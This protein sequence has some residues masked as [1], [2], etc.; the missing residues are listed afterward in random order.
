MKFFNTRLFLPTLIIVILCLLPACA[1]R[2][3]AAPAPTSKVLFEFK[4]ATDGPK[5]GYSLKAI[6]GRKD[7]VYVSD[8]QADATVFFTKDVESVGAGL[9][10]GDDD[11]FAVY[12]TFTK[13]GSEKIS[14]VTRSKIGQKL[15]LVMKG[16]VIYAATVREELS[17]G[18]MITGLGEKEAGELAPDMFRSRAA[19]TK[20]KGHYDP[21]RDPENWPANVLQAVWLPPQAQNTEYK[22]SGAY[23]VTYTADI[24]NRADELIGS[25]ARSMTGKKWERLLY[26]PRE[27]HN[28]SSAVNDPNDD[29]AWTHTWIECWRNEAGDVIYYRFTPSTDK[30]KPSC[31]IAAVIDYVPARIFVAGSKLMAEV[32]R[33]PG[34]KTEVATWPPYVLDSVWLPQMAERTKYDLFNGSYQ[35]FYQAGVCY[36]AKG[37]IDGM[38]ESMTAKGWRRLPYDPMNPGLKSAFVLDADK[39]EQLRGMSWPGSAWQDHWLDKAGNVVFYDYRYD[40]TY[41]SFLQFER[42][43]RKACSLQG[44]VIYFPAAVWDAGLNF[45]EEIKKERHYKSAPQGSLGFSP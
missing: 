14:Q 38:V 40:V 1:H 5:A 37:I 13:T 17:H 26:D 39:P 44:S 4:P 33:V 20:E 41:S 12:I 7:N 45:F 19:E 18:L 10:P 9:S 30:E 29:K 23:E 21:D 24:C 35:V 28:A 34:S 36:P 11:T 42:D 6:Q 27:P 15:A 22:F 32:Q 8:N 2:Q 16:S 31:S 3:I 25:M 43:L